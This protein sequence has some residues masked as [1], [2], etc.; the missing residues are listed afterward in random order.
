MEITRIL[1]T[2]RPGPDGRVSIHLRVC[3]QGN[4]VRLSSGEKVVPVDWD[5]KKE[6]V[7]GRAK[8]SADIN[9]RLDTYESGLSRFAY[10]TQ[11]AGVVLTEAMVRAEVERIRVQELGRSVSRIMPV[12]QPGIPSLI[13][14]LTD[15]GQRLPGG[16][17]ESTA[18][19]IRAIRQ[20]LD[21]FAPGIG[22]ADLKINTLNQ[23]KNYWM[24]EIGLSD[25][26]ISAYFGS[27]RGALKYAIMQ[28]YP[29]PA[30]YN[31][32][33]G[34]AAE[35]I[36]PALTRQHLFQLGGA[37]LPTGVNSRAVSWLFRM[38]CY[39]GLR[40]SDLGQL[41]LSS[42]RVIE[43]QPCL[44]ALQQKARAT[45]ALPLVDEAVSLLNQ[46]PDGFP[47]PYV[48]DYNDNLKRIGRTAGLLEPVSVSSR[49]NGKLL[50]SALPLCDTLT[51]HTAR[52]TFASLM[53]AGGL[54]TKV[55]QQLMGHSSLASTEKYIKLP[56]SVVLSQTLNAWK[57]SA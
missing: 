27:F 3:W 8:F 30:D 9:N 42:V 21:G 52:R 35:V 47:V 46:Q 24:E 10:Q 23:L 20:H 45:I 53:S 54:N 1:R 11:N 51:S 28:G 13:D 12:V 36:R 56:S 22:W 31:L 18:R 39:T 41:R 57:N 26:S 34:R 14:F 44:V 5:E 16:L 33:S 6:L 19:Q 7:R 29:V 15:Y 4:K 50:H 43:N 48:S 17:S 25:N 49:Y 37:E 55:L 2:D 32:V 38:A 40:H